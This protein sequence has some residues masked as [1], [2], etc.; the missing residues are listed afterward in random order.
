MSTRAAVYCRAAVGSQVGGHF[1]L[2]IQEFR[3]REHCREHD[4]TIVSSIFEVGLGLRAEQRPGLAQLRDLMHRHEIDVIVVA[5]FDRIAREMADLTAFTCEAEECS[6]RV[7]SMSESSI[8]LSDLSAD[9]LR[10]AEKFKRSE[11]RRRHML[12]RRGA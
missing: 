10:Q 1:G 3:L 7:E 11:I 9:V 6:V 8:L 12:K 5:R 4:Y 2:S